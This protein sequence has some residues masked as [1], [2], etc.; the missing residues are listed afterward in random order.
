MQFTPD[1]LPT[2]LI[3]LLLL[4]LGVRFRRQYRR[5]RQQGVLT[6]GIVVGHNDGPIVTFHTT[7]QQSI[8]VKPSF[9]SSKSHYYTGK[10]VS[11]YYNP[12]NPHDF[13]LDTLEHQAM[14]FLFIIGGIIF[15]VGGLCIQLR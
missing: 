4:W 2:V 12:D 5:L 8:T 13:V 10:S 9:N 15:F 11:L 6:T 7:D 3:G 1:Q 14:P